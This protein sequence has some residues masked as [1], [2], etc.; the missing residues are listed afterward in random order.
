MPFSI[1]QG[2]IATIDADAVVR[3]AKQGLLTEM[4]E[5]AAEQGVVRCTAD[6]V[7]ASD[8]RVKA[9]YV[10]YVA[11][12]DFEDK[13]YIWIERFRRGLKN[14]LKLSRE[15]GAYSAAF[16]LVF[17]EV[18]N[19][20]IAEE[21]LAVSRKAV[22]EFLDEFDM[23]I[24]LVVHNMNLFRIDNHLYQSIREY[25]E[26]KREICIVTHCYKKKNLFKSED[27]RERS[28]LDCI[29]K[30]IDETF[31]QLLLR[32][33]DER[34]LKDSEVYKRANIDRKLFSKI[35]TNKDYNPKKSTVISFAVALE[36][37]LDETKDFLSRAGYAFSPSS[38]ADLIV[39]YFIENKIYNIFV[40]NEALFKYNQPAL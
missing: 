9:K 14:A 4:S 27:N 13:S 18:R 21:I 39:S 2:D 31:S 7:I 22:A 33:I 36:L 32:L 3:P 10:I 17:G 38:I 37:S 26:N 5:M 6:A 19:L 24:F 40:I 30:K 11:E 29:I 16:P 20:R 15:M 23:D 35:R 34:G 25:I 28:E 1:I 8:N 12:P